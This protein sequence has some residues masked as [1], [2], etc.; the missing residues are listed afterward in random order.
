[1]FVLNI[2]TLIR[3]EI[4][5][6]QCRCWC[7]ILP[8]WRDLGISIRC[9]DLGGLDP[10]LS[11]S[12]INRDKHACRIHT[13]VTIRAG[14]VSLRC[15]NLERYHLCAPCRSRHQCLREPACA[16]STQQN[17][18]GTST[19]VCPETRA[20]LSRLGW[21]ALLEHSLWWSV[22]LCYAATLNA[23]RR[24]RRPDDWWRVHAIFEARHRPSRS[25]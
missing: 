8:S 24:A 6:Q 9:I 13:C 18:R 14:R 1:M 4:W 23:G 2:I 12:T 7:A 5:C 22:R 16:R 17:Y 25:I 20:G 15:A 10:A 19:H 21:Q 3:V 11:R